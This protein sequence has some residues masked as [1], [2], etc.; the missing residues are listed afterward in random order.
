MGVRYPQPAH[1]FAWLADGFAELAAVCAAAASP[2]QRIAEHGG[3]DSDT[4]AVTG[5]AYRR[6]DGALYGFCD[7]LTAQASWSRSGSCRTRLT[8]CCCNRHSIGIESEVLSSRESRPCLRE[9]S[10]ANG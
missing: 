7:P 3:N 8:N 9:L 10:P 6:V 5:Q 2:P 1:L 4:V